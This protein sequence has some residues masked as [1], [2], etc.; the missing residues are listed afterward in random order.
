MRKFSAIIAVTLFVIFAVAD[1]VNDFIANDP[2][3]Y[4]SEQPLRFVLV[5]GIAIGGGLITLAFYRLSPR[6]QRGVKLFTLGS[7]ASCL[8]AFAGCWLI[9]F[10]RWSLQLG[11]AASPVFIIVAPLFFGVVALLL[12]FEFYR[13][14]KKQ[15]I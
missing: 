8:T 6:L 14:L 2:I 5:A 13:V 10:V 3:H 7:A 9:F 1:L 15:A 4:F 11:M 12:W